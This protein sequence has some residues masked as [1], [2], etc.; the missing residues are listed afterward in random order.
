MDKREFQIADKLCE[1]LIN[2]FNQFPNFEEVKKWLWS[3]KSLFNKINIQPKGRMAIAN[4][5]Y[6]GIRYENIAKFHSLYQKTEYEWN[7]LDHIPHEIAIMYFFEQMNAFMLGHYLTEDYYMGK[8]QP[9]F[10][11]SIGN[12]FQE[13]QD[14]GNKQL[15]T[16][17]VEC[18]NCNMKQYFFIGTKD[19][20]YLHLIFKL[21]N[22]TVKDLIECR[23]TK[24]ILPHDIDTN[25]QV[26][27]DTITP[28][29]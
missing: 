13:L 6:E 7:I 10:I 17:I 25:K 8:D 11:Y 21:E 28:P 16:E 24:C 27:L 18:S 26:N 4:S 29:F 2:N 19:G 12:A 20:S 3:N 22:G 15:Y 23:E 5:N 14:R 1:S 9:E